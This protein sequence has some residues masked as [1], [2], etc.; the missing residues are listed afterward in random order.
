M[1]V[2][3]NR[4]EL[5]KAIDHNYAALRRTLE[6]VPPETRFE[7]T[8][9]AHA[10]GGRMSVADLLAYLIGWNELVLKWLARDAAGEP[11]DFPETGF[12]WNQLG[13]LAGKFY[14]DAS[15]LSY[16][17]RLTRL[18]QARARVVAEIEAR[19]D[20]VLYGRAWYGKWTMGR[21]IQFNTAAPY[22]NARGRIRRW[23]KA[24]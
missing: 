13:R 18:D 16:D 1:S 22:A 4:L 17:E 11:V 21:M 10:R 8:M 14:A 5:L 9:D 20:D 7:A 2:P 15:P 3:E 19:S 6:T 12:K 23:L 24:K